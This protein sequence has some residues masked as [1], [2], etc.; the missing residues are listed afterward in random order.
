[1]FGRDEMATNTSLPPNSTWI[2]FPHFDNLVSASTLMMM[3]SYFVALDASST[4]AGL[5]S[6]VLCST[7]TI[8]IRM[9]GD[10]STAPEKA[11]SSI[12]LEMT[13]TE[14]T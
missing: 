12:A 9:R 3:S 10:G 5:E 8:S 1:M 6:S 14:E 2:T 13:T 7:T 4:Y 11:S